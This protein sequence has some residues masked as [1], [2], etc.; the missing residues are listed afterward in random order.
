MIADW[1]TVLSQL[2]DQPKRL[3]NDQL[4]ELIHAAEVLEFGELASPAEQYVT[5]MGGICCITTSPTIAV[6]ALTPQLGSFVVVELPE[7]TVG[8]GLEGR[9]DTS[10]I[11]RNRLLL[12][13]V[14][15]R[16]DRVNTSF[17]LRTASLTQVTE[18]KDQLAKEEYL[19]LKATV[20]CRDLTTDALTLLQTHQFNHARL[21]QLLTQYHTYLRDAFQFSFAHIDRLLDVALRAG[22]LGGKI[23]TAG[24]GGSLFV[25]APDNARAVADALDRAGAK[26]TVV[27]V[28]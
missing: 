11:T 1:L 27:H 15:A 3:T 19:L 4:A 6:Q 2:A 26:A 20:A 28:M 21:G 8:T 9:A 7:S 14:L 17:S 13:D 18:Y 23:N 24:G 12:D 5:A 10:P 16:I 22:G 25:Y